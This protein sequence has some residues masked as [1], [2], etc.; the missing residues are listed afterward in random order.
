MDR[1]IDPCFKTLLT[2][3]LIGVVLGFGLLAIGQ[4]AE[5]QT[6]YLNWPGKPVNSGPSYTPRP[7]VQVGNQ[8]YPVPPSPYGQVGDPY[9]RHLNWAGKSADQSHVDTRPVQPQPYMAPPSIA[10][11]P[12]RDPQT[13]F[14]PSPQTAP[15]TPPRSVNPQPAPS[16]EHFPSPNR[17]QVPVQES[18][19]TQETAPPLVTSPS[20]VNTAPP[21][22]DGAYHIPP[23]SKYYRGPANTTEAPAHAP[24][25][26]QATNEVTKPR[27]AAKAVTSPKPEAKAL[28]H[29]DPDPTATQADI[30]EDKSPAFVIRPPDH[31]FVPGETV[32]DPSSQLPRLYSLHREYGLQPDQTV[33]P[34]GEIL[35]PADT[36]AAPSQSQ[37]AL[38]PAS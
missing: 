6:Q 14:R 27:N 32:T 18:M 7:E 19:P 35:A 16:L 5:A 17:R 24:L 8:A 4:V 20:T 28:A 23:S 21:V 36:G 33:L 38:P 1:R 10:P 37:S 34:Q 9:Q 25:P 15:V 11:M 12:R 3:P 30:P 29:K 31:H 2:R 26:A 13:D 22:N